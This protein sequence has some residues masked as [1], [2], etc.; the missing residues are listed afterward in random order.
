MKVIIAGSRNITD[1]SLVKT[2]IQESAFEIDCVVSGMA[3]GVD[4]LGESWAE[5][6]KKKHYILSS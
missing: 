6:N 2:A 5:K 4:S 1:Y 3:K